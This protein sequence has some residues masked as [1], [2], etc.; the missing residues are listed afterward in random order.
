MQKGAEYDDDC[1][2]LQPLFRGLAQPFSIIFP[3]LTPKLS[4]KARWK[5]E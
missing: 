4:L 2:L 3:G 5:A 1:Q